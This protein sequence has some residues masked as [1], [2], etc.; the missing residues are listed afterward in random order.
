MQPKQKPM[1]NVAGAKGAGNQW[2]Q[3]WLTVRYIWFIFGR[4]RST[5]QYWYR[6]AIYFDPI[7]II[8][9]PA[10]SKWPFDHPNGGHLAPEKVT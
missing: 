3:W 7:K 5:Y 10:S 8:K 1:F 9:V 4:F 6:Q 2:I